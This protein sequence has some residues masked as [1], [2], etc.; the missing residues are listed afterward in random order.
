[1]RALFGDVFGLSSDGLDRRPR[2]LEA[3]KSKLQRNTK[4]QT[5]RCDSRCLELGIWN[6]FGA[7]SLGFRAFAAKGR[8]SVRRSPCNLR[9]ANLPPARVPS[10]ARPRTA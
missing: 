7:W 9:S 4:H 10:G 8:V 5:P 2:L 1:M 3:P 6:F